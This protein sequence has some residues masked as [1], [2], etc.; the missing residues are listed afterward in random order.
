M[1]QEILKQRNYK[2]VK[3]VDVRNEGDQLEV[4]R[5]KDF[6]DLV[7]NNIRNNLDSDENQDHSGLFQAHAMSKISRFENIQE[8]NEESGSCPEELKRTY[9]IMKIKPS[10]MEKFRDPK[11][12]AS[13]EDNKRG[14]RLQTSSYDSKS[15]N[16]FSLNA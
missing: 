15:S 3:Q 9:D 1:N 2:A 4:E 10:L 13:S 14:L 16:S 11:S 8:A 12:S 6:S 5:P 7:A